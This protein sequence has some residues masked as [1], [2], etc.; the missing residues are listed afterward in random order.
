[1]FI[2]FDPETDTSWDGIIDNDKDS[3]NPGNSFN[4]HKWNTW[5]DVE[6]WPYDK[7]FKKKILVSVKDNNDNIAT[8]LIDL[9]VY[10][11]V[12]KIT[13]VAWWKIVGAL[14][15]SISEEPVDIYRYRNWILEKIKTLAIDKTSDKW[16]FNVTSESS[17]SWLTIRSWSSEIAKLN[18]TTGK[19][20]L[21]STDYGFKVT[22]ATSDNKTKIQIYSKAKW[23]IVYEQSFNLPSPQN[24]Q[25]V[26]S[27]DNL[28]KW[29]YFKSDIDGYKLIKN[30]S[31]APS[32]AN[33]AFIVNSENK[34]VIWIW[35]DWNIYIMDSSYKLAYGTNW[36]YV[37]L[38]IVNSAG[39]SVGSIYFK[40]SAV[41]IIK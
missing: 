3:L 38:S 20:D 32:L 16:E 5:Y 34:A 41:Y 11:P 19:I 29:I 25:S 2:D 21:K 10:V 7:P 17:A 8:S 30:P 35:Q 6:M 12:P 31:N 33:G 40:I 22:G 1:V 15:E 28:D 9:E 13:D 26:S 18:E 36:E 23:N 24:L 14:D 4:V 27:F 39:A 37:M